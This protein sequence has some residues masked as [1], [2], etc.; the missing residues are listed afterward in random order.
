VYKRNFAPERCNI[1]RLQAVGGS[2]AGARFGARDDRTI[3]TPPVAG[4]P[5]FEF[6]WVVKPWT[7]CTPSTS[8]S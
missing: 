6:S 5:L 4:L 7:A 3:G 2:A 1:L 8:R